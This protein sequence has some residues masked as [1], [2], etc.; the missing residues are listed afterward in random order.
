MSMGRYF[1][2][3]TTLTGVR[4]VAAVRGHDLLAPM[5]AVGL[6]P[7]LLV[8]PEEKVDFAAY[9]ELLERCAVAWDLPDLGLRIAPHQHIEVLGPVALVTRMERSVSA[10]L[11]A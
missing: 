6:G 9:C 11:H 10:A 7:K 4:E 3:A 2:R 8:T 5:R 1:T